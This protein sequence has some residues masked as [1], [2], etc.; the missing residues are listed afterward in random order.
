[1]GHP[2]PIQHNCVSQTVTDIQTTQCYC[3]SQT[4]TDIQ[5]T[6]CYCVPQTVTDIQT[7]QCYCVPQT[8]TD[9]QTTQCYC[10]SQAV[11]DIQTT[12]C[13]C[14]SQTVTDIQTTQCYC[15]SQTVTNIQQPDVMVCHR[16]EKCSLCCSDSQE[17]HRLNSIICWSLYWHSGQPDNKCEKYTWKFITT[18]RE[19]GPSLGHLNA[20]SFAQVDGVLIP[21]KVK[22]I[23]QQAELAQ[24]VP[25]RLRPQNFL[26]YGTT[27]VVGQP[28]T[29]AAFNP[30][31]IPGTHF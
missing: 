9:I 20:R 3:V 22:V 10:V 31:E 7:T 25:D 8:V 30:G 28:Y 13:Y 21:V 16:Q 11:T 29:P 2:V 15:V 14:V 19:I 4:V 24:G 5:T 17:T 18:L 1:V 12:E 6:Q 26:T 23:L 27:R